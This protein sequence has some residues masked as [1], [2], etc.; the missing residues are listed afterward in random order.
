MTALTPRPYC[1]HCYVAATT[2]KLLQ[3][4]LTL[5][6]SMALLSVFL[7]VTFDSDEVTQPVKGNGSF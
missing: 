4:C 1:F 5:H 6:D 7:F 3:S 2:A